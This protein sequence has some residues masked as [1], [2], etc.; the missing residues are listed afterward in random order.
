MAK[1]PVDMSSEQKEILGVLSKRHLLYSAVGAAT[2]YAYVPIVFK[3]FLVLG[4][5]PA[6]ITSL[7]SALPVV[8]VVAFFGFMRVDKLNMN[9]DYYYYIKLTRKMQ[10]GSWRKGH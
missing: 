2:L 1:V 8:F 9:R 5:S 4:I 10:Y 6:I 7:I 3:L